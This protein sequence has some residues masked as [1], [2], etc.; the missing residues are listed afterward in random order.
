MI[1]VVP[2]TR[3]V[4]KMN[5]SLAASLIQ[6]FL[7]ANCTARAPSLDNLLTLDLSNFD[8]F[9]DSLRSSVNV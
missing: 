4:A 7:V 6:P 9:L 8:A 3:L 1:V 2:C 5:A